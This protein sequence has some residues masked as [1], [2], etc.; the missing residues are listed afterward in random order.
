MI[1]FMKVWGDFVGNKI[2][3][4]VILIFF[5]VGAL[6]LKIMYYNSGVELDFTTDT[7]ISNLVKKYA[8]EYMSL[9]EN[10]EYE[11]AYSKLYSKDFSGIEAFKLYC[12][13]RLIASESGVSIKSIKELDDDEYLTVVNIYTPLF[14]SNELLEKENYKSKSIEI[15]IKLNGLFDYQVYMEEQYND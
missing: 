3:A 7:K 4:I 9:I 6:L 15:K 2:R 14:T 8:L 1:L 11:K 5:I 13:N 10:E 12:S